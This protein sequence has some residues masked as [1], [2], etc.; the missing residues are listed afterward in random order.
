MALIAV[1]ADKGAPGVTTTAVALAALWPRRVLLAETDPSG[2]DLVYRSLGAD[3]RPLDPTTGMLSL[4]ATARRGIAA[5][6]LWDHAQRISGGLDVLVGL[7]ASEQAGGL[8]GQ[9]G[10]L[11]RA[12]AELA[13]SPHPE[14]AADVLADCGRLDAS[15]P[16]TALLPHAALLLLVSRAQPE[17]IAHVRDRAQALHAKLHGQQRGAAQLAQPQIGVLLIADA[18]AGGRTAGQVN[19]MLIASGSG[20]SVV[21]LIA[22]DELGA[23]QL[24][25]RRRGRLDRSLLVRSARKVV[26]D[27]HQTYRAELTPSG[28]GQAAPPPPVGPPVAGGGAPGVPVVPPQYG[29]P[30]YGPPQYGPPVPPPAGPDAPPHGRPWQPGPSGAVR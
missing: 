2:G 17:N 7:A 4:A 6:Q 10:A 9:W 11:G 14:V 20:A 22:E 26:A 24:A 12:F 15:S 18:S 29:P 28:G 19:E 21:G 13:Q 30:G 5:E 16:L 25:G 8:A 3:G 27:L 1:A 23:G